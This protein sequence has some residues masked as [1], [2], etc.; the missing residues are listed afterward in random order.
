M[1]IKIK[2]TKWQEA[3]DVTSKIEKE[4]VGQKGKACLIFCP[5]TT[6]GLTI[7]EGADPAVIEDVLE[8]IDEL[9]PRLDFKH[10]EGNSISHIKSSLVG[11]SLLIPLENCRLNLGKWQKIFFLEFDG[12]REREIWVEL[13]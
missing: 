1:R 13:L 7:N 6:C 12:P 3:V 2:T 8:A 9:T 11:S 10:K 5:H 4:I